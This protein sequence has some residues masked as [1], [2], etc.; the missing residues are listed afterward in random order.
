MSGLEGSS[1]K[2]ALIRD[3]N[4]S[5]ARET[6]FRLHL[7][8]MRRTNERLR[9]NGRA[10]P[11]VLAILAVES[12]YRPRVLRAIE[13]VAWLVLSMLGS[14]SAA[15]VTVGIAQARVSHWRDLGLLRSERF[16]LGHLASV[17]DPD[18]N[19]EVCRRYLSQRGMLGESDATALAAAYAGG[20]RRN[21]PGMLRRA[22]V[23]F[24]R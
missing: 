23:A 19:Y 7:R 17:M 14:P 24:A 18:A 8:R 2:M 16:S 5:P 4:V 13:Y 20:P 22:L 15:R 6:R 9:R 21:Y 1:G 12:F 3:A 10:D 11:E